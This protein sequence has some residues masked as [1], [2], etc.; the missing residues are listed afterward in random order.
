MIDAVSTNIEDFSHLP[1]GSNVLYLDGH[2]EYQRYP[3]ANQDEA[4]Q[5]VNALVARILGAL[6]SG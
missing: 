1:G 5:V 6:Y 3:T 4:P 2:V